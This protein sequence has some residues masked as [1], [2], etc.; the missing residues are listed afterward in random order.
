M[1]DPAPMSDSK[2]T[3]SDLNENA[4]VW[5]AA[6][7]L[8]GG[9]LRNRPPSASSGAYAIAWSA[10]STAP[11]RSRKDPVNASRSAELLTSSSST[12]TSSDSRLAARS[13]IRRA[14]PKLVRTTEAPSRSARSAAWNAIESFVIPP[15]ITSFLPSRIKA[16][17]RSLQPRAAQ[18]PQRTGKPLARLG[19]LDQLV[20][21]SGGSGRLGAQVLVGVL[22]RQ[23]RTLRL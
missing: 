6:L 23:P 19:R 8:S 5:K 7:A 16:A 22:V 17:S 21:E 4:L 9:V 11:H 15:V 2:A 3:A 20:D 10:P 14:R 18:R 12:S 13:V 1:L